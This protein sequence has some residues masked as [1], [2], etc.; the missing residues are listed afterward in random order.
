MTCVFGKGVVGWVGLFVYI[1]DGGR[2][3][4]VLHPT[5]S[6]ISE[7]DCH[8]TAVARLCSA[9]GQLQL[10][11]STRRGV[12]GFI[13]R[14]MSYPGAIGGAVPIYTSGSRATG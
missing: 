12:N 1:V 3:F 10:S 6:S 2:L 9:V 4:F 8:S 11:S 7:G 13:G 14:R 5:V